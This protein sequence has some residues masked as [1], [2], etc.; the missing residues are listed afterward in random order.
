[1]SSMRWSATRDHSATS[2]ST[3]MRLTTR[4]ATSSSSTQHRWG[5]SM[6]NMVEQGQISG[7]SDSTRRCGCSAPSRCTRWISVPMPSTVPAGARS[8]AR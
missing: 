4:P 3:V 7:S 8:T 1:M 6:R 5:A 2:P